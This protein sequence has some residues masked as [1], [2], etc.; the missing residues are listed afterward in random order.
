MC[1]W[2]HFE[3]E[4]KVVIWFSPLGVP[5]PPRTLIFIFVYFLPHINLLTLQC[6]VAEVKWL[7]S[8]NRQEYRESTKQR[9]TEPS[10]ELN[11]TT[12]IT[13]ISATCPSFRLREI[14]KYQSSVSVHCL[15]GFAYFLFLL[16]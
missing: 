7:F 11:R 9:N 8:V 13:E 15:L 10:C 1:T 5:N 2:P 6:F 16:W 12:A 3:G 4:R 14:F